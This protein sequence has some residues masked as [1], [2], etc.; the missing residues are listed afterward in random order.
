MGPHRIDEG[1]RVMDK[2]VCTDRGSGVR[3][4]LVKVSELGNSRPNSV[5]PGVA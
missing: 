5:S 2:N 3:V 4:C 1:V